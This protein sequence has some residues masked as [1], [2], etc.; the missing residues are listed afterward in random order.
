MGECD[1]KEE[2]TLDERILEFSKAVAQ[3]QVDIFTKQKSTIITDPQR[4]AGIYLPFGQTPAAIRY[5]LNSKTII[6]KLE[7][8]PPSRPS[9]PKQNTIKVNIL[10][11]YEVLKKAPHEIQFEWGKYLGLK[12]FT[13][14]SPLIKC[15]GYLSSN[16]SASHILQALEIL[17]QKSGDVTLV[18]G[19]DS[20]LLAKF[21]I[22]GLNQKQKNV[23][24]YW[25]QPLKN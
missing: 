10:E 23:G 14:E 8:A 19:Y 7:N 12:R 16:Y 15:G 25:L 20:P 22:R 2:F 3:D 11:L 18:L 9:F 24:L 17:R 4:I 6:E 1:G 21:R 13:Y 5:D